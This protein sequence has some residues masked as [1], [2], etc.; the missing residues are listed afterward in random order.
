MRFH[1]RSLLLFLGLLTEVPDDQNDESVDHVSDDDTDGCPENELCR[2]NIISL[3]EE[4]VRWLLWRPVVNIRRI[5][6]WRH[7]LMIVFMLTNKRLLTPK[8]YTTDVHYRPPKEPPH[9]FF[10]KRY[11][12]A[13]T[14]L[15]LWTSISIVIAYM[16]YR[17][18]ILVIWNLCQ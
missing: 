9:S 11:D 5:V 16:I 17:F 8:N 3:T 14:Q 6:L 7:L 12:I 15:V 2:C 18:I 1:G 10:R 13:S 4:R